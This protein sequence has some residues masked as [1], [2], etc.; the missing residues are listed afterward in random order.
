MDAVAATR[1]ATRPATR[2]ATRP[3]TQTARAHTA[4]R[5]PLAATRSATL[6]A[7]SK[8]DITHDP[9][10]ALAAQLT[11]HLIRPAD[12]EY[13]EARLVHNAAHDRHPAAIVRVADA[14]D[15]ATTVRFARAAQMAVAVRSGGHSLAG[16]GTGDGVV[17]IDLRELRGLHIDPQ[18]RLAWAGAGLTAGDVTNAA[19][20][21]SLAVPFG[22]TGSVGVGGIT[23]GGG[24]GFLARKFGM[25]IDNLV[26]VEIVTA[27]GRVLTASVAENPDLFW[28]VRGGGGNFGIVTRFCYRLQPVGE[29][30]LGGA[31][32]MPPT[33]EVLRGLVPVA[34]S[35]PEELTTISMLM[36][37][38]AAPFVP[39]ELHGK[40]SLVVMFVHA[41]DPA[42][43]EQAL[44]PFRALATP[45][46][47]FV[48]PMPYAGIYTLT[49]G[50]SERHASMTRSMFMDAFDDESV[51]AVLRAAAAPM[52][53]VQIRVLGGVMGRVAS[54]ATAFAHRRQQVLL[55]IIT[56]LPGPAGTE[57]AL[58][59]MQWTEGLYG[60]L[61]PAARG[62]YANFLEDEGDGRIREAYPGDTYRRLV[63]LKRRYDPTNLFRLNQNIRP[64]VPS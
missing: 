23:T 14:A 12:P 38:P 41:G 4:I 21:M 42:Q 17:V 29:L 40:Q 43:G 55:T 52:G 59:A 36:P 51:D 19:S 60:A 11:G 35:A 22:D 2:T 34:A 39:E 54:G 44:A 62:V 26:S 5:A 56:P 27:D 63:A 18:S 24:I 32:F 10:A 49:E 33:R 50:A 46:A 37:I 45:L 9:L 1:P 57:A 25:T 8:P 53:M 3:V 15:V 13:D 47:E 28:A 58:A 7:V 61:R 30:V 16:H 64:G 6:G 48:A 20:P 31:L